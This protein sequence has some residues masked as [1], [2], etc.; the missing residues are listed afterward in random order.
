M[1]KP[2]KNKWEKLH[3]NIFMKSLFVT[4]VPMARNCETMGRY[5]GSC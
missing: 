5:I 1:V 3:D 2:S 4:L